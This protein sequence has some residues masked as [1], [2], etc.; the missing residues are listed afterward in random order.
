M[1]LFSRGKKKA[2]RKAKKAKAVGPTMQA[3]AQPMPHMQQ[4]PRVGDLTVGDYANGMPNI[5]L[6]E[7]FKS[8]GRQL[9][10]L[11]IL[12]G[13][14]TAAAWHFTKDFKRTYTGEATLLVQLGDEYVYQPV[15]GQAGQS[16]LS[17]T[18]DTIALNEVAIIKNPEIIKQVFG[19]MTSG[20]YARRFDP[21]GAK[22]LRAA[23]NNKAD[24]QEAQAE[25]LQSMDEAFYVAPR[26]K[27]SI[28]DLSFKHED[29]E[30]AIETLSRL[31]T[32]YEDYR[33][34]IFVEGS[35]DIISERRRETEKQLESNERAISRF[36]S[37]SGI[38]DF[39]SEQT[40]VRKRTEELR[41]ALNLQR[42]QI[43]ETESALAT[44]EAQLRGISPQIDLYVDDRASQRVA[45]AELELKQLLA[46]Y[47]PSSDPVRQKQT[48]LAEL[49]SL[50]AGNG[51]RAAGGRRVGPNP[52]YQELLTR[53]NTLQSTADSYREKEFTL[54]RQLDSAD[55][56]VRKLTRLSPQYQ[57][58]L[59]EQATL[60]QRLTTYNAKE[61]EALINQQLAAA[62]SE[63]VKVLSKPEFARKGRNMRLV[64]FALATVAWGFTLFMI[65]LLRV[66]LDPRL[67]AAPP[68]RRQAVQPEAAYNPIPEAVGLATTATATADYVE[69]AAAQ[70]DQQAYEPAAYEA[71]PAYDV[72]AQAPY[73]EQQPAQQL[74][75]YD[76]HFQNRGQQL[77][78]AVDPAYTQP[79]APMANSYA[80]AEG[81][82]ALDVASNPYMSGQPA[83]DTPFVAP[84]PPT[85][86]PQG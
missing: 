25:M 32:A 56:K 74:S 34:E 75:P 85:H 26:P 69:P 10:W 1:A 41:A 86:Q 4:G 37:K 71:A 50:Q 17:L 22:K 49:K 6:A 64:M 66:F 67:Y 58:L 53:R 39:G 48:E 13:L 82:A 65:A 63:N 19:E 79:V 59:R 38:S 68:P 9:P 2:S 57:G 23:G 70:H 15:N 77:T 43:A 80:Q 28:I 52:V 3:Q 54:Q 55:N 51:G 21:E 45:Q 30:I 8:F 81:S 61:Q 11:I 40:G 7:M 18:A 27:S 36:L 62:N 42:A 24:V 35:V 14:G 16:G 12:M 84:Y 73:A 44:V 5:R 72:P 33:R 47:L 29:A 78:Q 60:D 46:K 83:S 31:I 20:P 76:A